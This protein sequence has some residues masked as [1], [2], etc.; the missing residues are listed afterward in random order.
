MPHHA[1]VF[2]P[3]GS[4]NSS[5]RRPRTIAVKPG[6]SPDRFLVARRIQK[7]AKRIETLGRCEKYP[8]SRWEAPRPAAYAR[9]RTV[10]F[11][12]FEQVR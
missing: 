4:V 11:P 7:A 5:V 2:H 8:Q 10:L 9:C 1:G 3:D 12:P 6:K